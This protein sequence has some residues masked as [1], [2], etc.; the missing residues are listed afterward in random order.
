MGL[1]NDI[2]RP[3]DL[4]SIRKVMEV[5][6][7]ELADI[8]SHSSTA[9]RTTAGLVKDAEFAQGMCDSAATLDE[10]SAGLRKV[11]T[12]HRDLKA[13]MGIYSAWNDIDPSTVRSNPKKAARAFGQ[14]FVSVGAIVEYLPVPLKGY[15]V[16]FTEVG[17]FFENIQDLWDLESPNTIRGKAYRVAF[18]VYRDPSRCKARLDALTCL[19]E[20]P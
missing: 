1:I 16:F 17:D 3:I 19:N 14:L 9:V 5:G 13:L 8:L 7:D 2:C 18:P 15:A 6:P 20:E 4:K 12:I 11:A 10:V